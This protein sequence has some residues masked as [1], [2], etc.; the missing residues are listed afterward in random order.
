MRLVD[1]GHVLDSCNEYRQT[2][3]M[4]ASKLCP[5]PQDCLH[6]KVGT[7]F[8]SLRMTFFIS[9]LKPTP[10]S[11]C[12]WKAGAEQFPLGIGNQ[13]PSPHISVETNY[14]LDECCTLTTRSILLSMSRKWTF[15]PLVHWANCGRSIDRHYSAAEMLPE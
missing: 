7:L 8:D 4:D 3:V 2:Y 11:R 6:G 14:N 1:D 10:F 12:F 9:Y 13:G 5:T 15:P